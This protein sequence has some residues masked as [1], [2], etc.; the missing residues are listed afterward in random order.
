MSVQQVGAPE[1]TIKGDPGAVEGRIA[2]MRQR[3]TQYDTIADSVSRITAEGW[4]GKASDRF[5]ERFE[6][7]PERW[8]VA[9]CGFR[10]A[11]DGLA[12][13]AS[14][15][16]QAQRIADWCRSE[17]ARGEKVT[18]EARAAYD[19]DVR[20]GQRQKAEWEAV[21]G[22]GT[23]TLTIVPFVDP[24]E[25]I[26]AGAVTRFQ[27][28]CQALQR[29][30]ED[31]AAA[32]RLG[33]EGAPASRNWFETGLAYIG[34]FFLGAGEA[35]YDLAKLGLSLTWGPMIEIG[36]VLTG[37]LTI[38]ELAAKQQLKL[39][40]AQAM[41]NALVTD[42]VA[43]GKEMGKALLD[44]ETWADDPARALG[45]LAPDIIIGLAT[46]GTGTA[47]SR[48]GSMLARLGGSA[49][50]MA[51]GLARADDV[52][53]SLTAAN[54]LNDAN[55]LAGLS[56]EVRRLDRFLADGPST[57]PKSPVD[58]DAVPRPPQ[59]LGMD[60]LTDP[61][62]LRWVEE[63]HDAAP[64]LSRRGAFGGVDYSTNAGYDVINGALRGTDAPTPEAAWRISNVNQVFSDLPS[65]PGTTMRGTNVP[66]DVFKA[67]EKGERFSD[68]AFMS[69]STQ[70]HVAEG[71]ISPYKPNPVFLEV[72]GTSGVDIARLSAKASES[73]VLFKGSTLF[74][75]IGDPRFIKLP[76]IPDEVLHVVLREVD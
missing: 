41:W 37:D 34:G 65:T 56:D 60:A 39:E 17:Y 50:E 12:D 8:R 61:R 3:A 59:D 57:G 53:D 2:T 20:A 31:A 48:G 43:F 28:E 64:T 30:A 24:G 72:Q 62:V 18:T 73:E 75:V 76:G 51:A 45:R 7:E 52:A 23:F 35:L 68:P 74:D 38:E 67:L 27:E 54:R 14:A 63:T 49:D 10:R 47:A 33:C 9:G 4:K 40:T 15:L 70:R 66:D 69:T 26:R 16:A 46:A 1:F 6:L 19:E 25:P 42:P 36:R 13:Y 58:W 44:W 55:R 29:S 21:N 32:V 22:P 11:A 71:F 5:R